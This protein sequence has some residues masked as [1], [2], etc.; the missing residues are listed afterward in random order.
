MAAPPYPHSIAE[1]CAVA[2]L[3]E[4]EIHGTTKPEVLDI[5]SPKVVESWFNPPPLPSGTYF[6]YL[7]SLGFDDTGGISFTPIYSRFGGFP[8]VG[9]YGENIPS[10]IVSI[11]TTLASVWRILQLDIFKCARPIIAGGFIEKTATESLLQDDPNDSALRIQFA[12]RRDGSRDID[13]FLSYP[14]RCA[15][16]VEREIRSFVQRHLGSI[17]LLS[18]SNCAITID[19]RCSTGIQRLQFIF[20]PDQSP[21]DIISDFDIDC[22]CAYFDGKRTYVM[23]RTIEAWRRRVNLF[24]PH[25]ICT[26]YEGRLYK[27]YERSYDFFFH[28]LFGVSP[29]RFDLSLPTTEGGLLSILPMLKNGRPT[30]KDGEQPQSQPSKQQSSGEDYFD[31]WN[32]RIPYYYDRYVFQRHLSELLSDRHPIRV[33]IPGDYLPPDE[34][35][36]MKRLVSATGEEILAFLDGK[37]PESVIK[38][39]T[40]QMSELRLFLYQCPNSRNPVM[41]ALLPLAKKESQSQLDALIQSMQDFIRVRSEGLIEKVRAYR[42]MPLT[43]MVRREAASCSQRSSRILPRQ[44]SNWLCTVV[45]G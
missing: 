21:S 29:D 33:H 30:G 32:A 41:S 7:H 36:W 37:F 42:H 39:Y 15:D 14:S 22:C 20:S 44:Q 17:T 1:L 34:R 31:E 40:A 16:E 23:Q 6:S 18:M 27:Y 19:I 2:D 35:V 26:A 11:N 3:V 45:D 13:V 5:A 38:G 24:R 4:K 25:R 28:H 10:S 12:Y 43:E 9:R 8:L